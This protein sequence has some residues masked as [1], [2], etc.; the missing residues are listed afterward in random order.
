[1][2]NQHKLHNDRKL[3]RK[4]DVTLHNPQHKIRCSL[5]YKYI[6]GDYYY[7]YYFFAVISICHKLHFDSNKVKIYS[8][9]NIHIFL[10]PLILLWKTP[11]G[12]VFHAGS[13]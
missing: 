6:S 13:S 7:Y 12:M 1:M 2:K 10:Q 11:Y 4:R 3:T 8:F 5:A 9:S